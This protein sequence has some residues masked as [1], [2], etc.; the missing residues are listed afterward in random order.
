MN[1][2]CG[3]VQTMMVMFTNLK[4][5]QVKYFGTELCSKSWFDRQCYYQLTDWLQGKYHKVIFDIFFSSFPFLKELKRKNILVYGTIRPNRKDLRVI[6]D[7]KSLKR[8][9][10]TLNALQMDSVSINEKTANQCT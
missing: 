9:D 3:A 2:S 1:I 10:L 4:S 7:E 8:G 5:I 6:T